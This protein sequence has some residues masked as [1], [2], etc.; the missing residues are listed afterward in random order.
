MDSKKK[1]LI[2][3][4]IK[5]RISGEQTNSNENFLFDEFIINDNQILDQLSMIIFSKKF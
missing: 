4:R 5:Y 1:D 2:I 3:L